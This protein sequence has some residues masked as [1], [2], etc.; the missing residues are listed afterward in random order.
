MDEIDEMTMNVG[1]V[2]DLLEKRSWSWATLAREMGINKSTMNR[3]VRG[4]TLPGRKF[5]FALIDVFPQHA[6]KLFVR[7]PKKVRTIEPAEES[8]A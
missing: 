3:V 4:E 2:R 6:A 7:V 8:A 1:L 5:I